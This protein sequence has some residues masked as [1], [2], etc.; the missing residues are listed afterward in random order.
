MA[1][2]FDAALEPLVEF[3]TDYHPLTCRPRQYQ[4]HPFDRR[5]HCSTRNYNMI[6]EIER[7]QRSTRHSTTSVP[8]VRTSQDEIFKLPS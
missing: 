1:S 3:I 5:R 7:L 8:Q 4:P 6:I 2:T